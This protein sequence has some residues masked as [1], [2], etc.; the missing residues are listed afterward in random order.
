MLDIIIFGSY[1]LDK[2][3]NPAI[4][5]EIDNL[6]AAHIEVAVAS[7]TGDLKSAQKSIVNF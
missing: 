1:H 2:E 4:L 6:K 7:E 5:T 3:V